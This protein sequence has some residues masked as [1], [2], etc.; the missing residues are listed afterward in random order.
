M[1]I[2][3]DKLLG[4]NISGSSRDVVSE[5]VVMEMLNKFL[6]TDRVYNFADFISVLK[7]E[8]CDLI[9]NGDI[10]LMFLKSTYICG[11][12]VLTRYKLLILKRRRRYL[13]E[14]AGR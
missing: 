7:N 6:S 12:V 11:Y 5:T 10:P 4:M 14:K 13:V 2:T 8:T 9:E 3:L 1:Q